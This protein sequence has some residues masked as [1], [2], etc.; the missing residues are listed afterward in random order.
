MSKNNFQKTILITIIL[1]TTII[2]GAK[3]SSAEGEVV[4]LTIRNGS[5][6]IYTGSIPLQPAGTIQLDGHDLDANSVLSVLHD[7]DITSESFEITDL[8]YYSSFGSFYLNC[9]DSAC[10]DWQYTVNGSY[11][12]SGMDKVT[13]E[14]SENI[15]LYFGP[16]HKISISLNS[17]TTEENLIVS[18]QNYVY[19]NNEWELLTGVTIG[20]IQPDPSN[21]WTPIEIETK[22]IDDNGQVLF[23]SLPVGL[24]SVGIQEDYYSPSLD[25]T[26]IEAPVRHSSSG[27]NTG[28]S[29]IGTLIPVK[30]FSIPTAL[31]FLSKN[32]ENDASFG[33]SLYTDWTAIGIAKSGDESEIIKNKLSDYLKNNGLVSQIVTDN[34]RHAMA[35]MALDIDP[36]EGTNINYIN[37]IVTSY[38]G[39]QI[40][41]P[42]LINDDIF[43]LIVLSHVGYTEKDEM[44]SK[45]VSNVISYQSTDGSWESID[46][47][48]ASIQAL[49]NFK[50][51][52]KVE[53]SITKAELYLKN[54]QKEDGSFENPF[55]TSWAIQAMS[56]DSSLYLEVDRAIQYLANKQ[57][58]DGGLDQIEKENRIWATSY[59]IP[60]VMKLSWN[61][62]LKSFPKKEN[63]EKNLLPILISE[64]EKTT[65]TVLGINKEK[66]ITK[67]DNKLPVEEN[68]NNDLLSTSVINQTENTKIFSSITSK[69]LQKIVSPFISLWVFLGL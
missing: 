30:T 19:E 33:N 34:E 58:E 55:S 53:D 41:D 60:A 16:Q 54:I 29:Y 47:T 22:P 11:L 6:I 2:C 42:S 23:S 18:G 27:S 15:Y 43:A 44:I 28:G 56:L 45:I 13:L 61:D 65:G 5:S 62:I 1:L 38:N 7:A 59:A 40:G 67:T 8:Q 69:I 36:Y 21:P 57:L 9:I 32:Q 31:E 46:M 4:D 37:K 14:G 63:I 50:K 51:L 12:D 68:G 48:S 20:V 35:L 64:K 49:S 39:A 52:D 24:Y 66:N 10:N 26:V 17:I 25:L 3:I